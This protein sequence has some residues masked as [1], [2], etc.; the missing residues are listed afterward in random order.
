MYMLRQMLLQVTRTVILV[1]KAA[2]IHFSGHEKALFRLRGKGRAAIGSVEHKTTP[3][4]QKGTTFADY[5][6]HPHPWLSSSHRRAYYQCLYLSALSAIISATHM[7]GA[8]RTFKQALYF[9]KSSSHSFEVVFPR[10]YSALLVYG[11]Q[12]VMNIRR[13]LAVPF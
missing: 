6:Q 8:I 7:M 9:E 11:R 12:V 1:E 10:R 2:A 4:L 13:T 3:R 5:T